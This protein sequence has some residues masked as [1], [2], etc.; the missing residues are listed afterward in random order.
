M[1]KAEFGGVFIADGSFTKASAEAAITAGLADA[2]D[3]GKQ[4]IANPDLLR[5]FREDSSLNE[6]QPQTFDGKGP[7][8]YTDYPAPAAG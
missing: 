4:L 1:L 6:P 5:R 3:W 8:G 7:V 2:V